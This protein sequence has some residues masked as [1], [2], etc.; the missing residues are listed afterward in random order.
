MAMVG[1]AANLREA[2]SHAVVE[3]SV[4]NAYMI[5]RPG[6]RLGAVAQVRFGVVAYRRNSPSRRRRECAWTS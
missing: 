6:V 3:P 4:R 5:W 2:A 1:L